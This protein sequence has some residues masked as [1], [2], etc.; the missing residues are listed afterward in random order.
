LANYSNANLKF[1][2]GLLFDMID[3]AVQTVTQAIGR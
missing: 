1:F 3:P 2:P